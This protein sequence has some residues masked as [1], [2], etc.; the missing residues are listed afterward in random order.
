MKTELLTNFTLQKWPST[1]INLTIAS[2]VRHLTQEGRIHCENFSIRL[3]DR[4]HKSCILPRHMSE[5]KPQSHDSSSHPVEEKEWQALLELLEEIKLM[6]K[7]ATEVLLIGDIREVTKV[8]D[9]T[10]QY[11]QQISLIISS[12][13]SSAKKD[14]IR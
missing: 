9:E 5:T 13:Q 14:L 4:V 7:I 2:L 3:L 10:L 1:L 6:N 12:L 11:F 8:L